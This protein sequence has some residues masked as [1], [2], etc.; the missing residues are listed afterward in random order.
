MTR[1]GITS[2]PTRI[3]SLSKGHS[4]VLTEAQRLEIYASIGKAR[5]ATALKGVA[6]PNHA[7]SRAVDELDALLDT[8][9]VLSR[10]HLCEFRLADVAY[11]LKDSNPAFCVWLGEQIKHSVADKTGGCKFNKRDTIITVS[12]MIDYLRAGLSLSCIGKTSEDKV[13]V[14]WYFHGDADVAWLTSFDPEQTFQPRLHLKNSSANKFTAAYNAMEHRFDVGKSAAECERLL[15]RK[16]SDVQIGL[17]HTLVFFNEDDSQIPCETHRMEH[18]AFALTRAACAKVGVTVKRL[19]EDSYSCVDFRVAGARV[20]DK[21]FGWQADMRSIGRHPYDPDSIDVFQITDIDQ[22]EA[23][24]LSMRV[25]QEDGKVI[26]FFS[27]KELMRRSLTCSAQWKEDNKQ[28][29]YVLNDPA[30]IRGYINACLRAS[31]IPQ[32]TDRVF[33]S[34]MLAANKDMFGSKK[35]LQQRKTAAS[36]IEATSTSQIG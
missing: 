5:A 19:H 10:E 4:G 24:V 23:Y 17:K 2:Q 3:Q 25:I 34:N 31:E 18:K 12:G 1:A 21:L 13:D 28:H 30:G 15:Q 8:Q 33:Y 16:L 20:Q 29:L 14:V 11:S 7:E 22:N 36:S 32:L 27:E 26:S 35:Q 9:R 6:A